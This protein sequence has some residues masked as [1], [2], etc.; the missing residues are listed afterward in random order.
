[1]VQGTIG[2]LDPM[3]FYTQRLTEKSDVYS[4]GV[5]LI[6]LLTKKSHLHTFRW[7]VKALLHIFLLCLLKAICHKY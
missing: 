5:I 1:M 4:F 2:Y 7:M 3:Y 6:E